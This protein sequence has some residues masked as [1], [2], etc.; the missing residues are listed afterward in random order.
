MTGQIPTAKALAMFRDELDKLG[1]DAGEITELVRIACDAEVRSTNGL[2]L[3]PAPNQVTDPGVLAPYGR[4]LP[5]GFTPGTVV[6]P[7]GQNEGN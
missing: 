4:P 7:P 5:D 2:A 6:P 1:F 3:S